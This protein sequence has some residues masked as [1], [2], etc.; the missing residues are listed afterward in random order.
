M[1]NAS[2]TAVAR[3]QRAWESVEKE[4]LP[5][6]RQ[7]AS[8][9]EAVGLVYFRFLVP[10]PAGT[11]SSTSAPTAKKANCDVCFVERSTSLWDTIFAASP[12]GKTLLPTVGADGTLLI[13]VGVPVGKVEGGDMIM[14]L[15]SFP[16]PNQREMVSTSD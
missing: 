4:L 16:N 5:Y 1:I 6:A 2:H 3:H 15:R 8:T 7:F 10:A 12:E 14:S 13:C 11:A 9:F